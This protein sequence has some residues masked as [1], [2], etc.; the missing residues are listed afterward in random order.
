MD[1]G[2]EGRRA[3]VCASS[4]G[5]GFACARELASEGAEVWI[6]G[7]S[8]EKLAAAAARIRDETGAKV[9]EVAADLGTAPGR[10]QLLAACPAPDILVNNNG[11]P[12][13]R[14]FLHLDAEAIRAGIDANMVAPLELIRSVLPGMAERGFGRIVNITSITV[15][16]PLAGLD[17]SSGARAGLTAV[18]SGVARQYADRN[19]TINNLLPGKIGTERLSSVV[20]KQAEAAGVD[21]EAERKRQQAEIPA[22][23]FGTPE[24]F[25]FVCAMLCSGRGSYMTGRNFL[26]DGG[27]HHATF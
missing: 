3:V 1:L 21:G 16:M 11:G 2:L 10:A 7:R 6:N 22:G 13:P 27:L 17:L 18:L 5:L 24:E 14:D 12:P 25:A 23:R 26:L 9:H 19:V 8:A 4:Q 15:L 20:K